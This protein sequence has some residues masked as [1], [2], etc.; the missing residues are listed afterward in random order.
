MPTFDPM[1]PSN[2]G[3]STLRTIAARR[4]SQKR[5]LASA[6]DHVQRARLT[7]ATSTTMHGGP[8]VKSRVSRIK[9]T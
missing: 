2:S 9:S 3:G 6:A 5:R 7:R 1:M 8:N 4:P